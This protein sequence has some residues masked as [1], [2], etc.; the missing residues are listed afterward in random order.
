AILSSSIPPAPATRTRR[1]LHYGILIILL[2]AAGHYMSAPGQT[3]CISAMVDPMLADLPHIDRS[4]YS[5]AYLVGTL[6]AGCL[7]P[8]SGSLVDRFGARIMMPVAGVLLGLACTWM[9]RLESLASLYLGFL[10]LRCFGQGMLP[11]FSNW[12]IGE[13]FQKRRG[14]AIGLI[15]IGGA[16]STMTVPVLVNQDIHEFD[17]RHAWMLLATLTWILM[18]LPPLCLIRNRPEAIGLF[19]DLSFSQENTQRADQP[20]NEPS[21]TRAEALRNPTFWKLLTVGTTSAMVGTGLMF[22]QV[23]LLG[24]HDVSRAFAI[25]LISLQAGVGIGSTLIFGYL[26]D[27]LPAEKILSLSMLLLAIDTLLL[28][29]LPTPQTAILYAIIMGM[30]G[31]IMRTAGQVTWINFYGRKNQGAVCGAALAFMV[32]ASGLG[33]L[34]LAWSEKQTGSYNLGLWIFLVLPIISGLCV[35][36]ARKPVKRTMANG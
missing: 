13:W 27:R 33:P 26:T 28:I 31:G 2:A 23:A 8:I 34:P 12:L 16:L 7:L 36:S 18:I 29:Y 20:G 32:V 4:D 14:L 35:W 17:W 5:L 30:F 11:L 6:L 22:H 10:M 1:G 19:P 9:S 15:G 24:A 3:Y 21:W 25:N